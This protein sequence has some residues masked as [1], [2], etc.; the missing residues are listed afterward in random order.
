VLGAPSVEAVVEGVV[1]CALDAPA[2]VDGAAGVISELMLGVVV[3]V[4]AV[5]DAS[6]LVIGALDGAVVAYC[7]DATSGMNSNAAA[8][9]EASRIFFI[10]VSQER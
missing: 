4:G 6:G 2:T 10:S 5:A 9:A 7:A 8:A 1:V 3:V